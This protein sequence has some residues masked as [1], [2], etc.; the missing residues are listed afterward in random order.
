[1]AQVAD[2]LVDGAAN[3]KKSSDATTTALYTLL[4]LLICCTGLAMAATP[5]AATLHRF[6]DKAA[7]SLALGADVAATA[8]EAVAARGQFVVAVSGGSL[9]KLL[10]SGLIAHATGADGVAW[11]KWRVFFAD[12]RCVPHDHADSNQR[13]CEEAFL[14]PISEA[15][16]VTDDAARRPTVYGIDEALVDQPAAAAAAYQKALEGVAGGGGEGEACTVPRFDL[17]LLG[18][19]PD[20]HTCSLFP[21][22]ALFRGAA[23]QAAAGQWVAAIEDSPKPPAQRITLTLPVLNGARRVAFVA[24]GASKADVLPAAVARRAHGEGDGAAVLPAGSVVPAADGGAVAWYVDEAAAAQIP[25]NS[26]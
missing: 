18:M 24:A 15:L 26:L 13:G 20:G 5:P 22:H 6:A 10:A 19:G 9:P 16:G 23:E 14:Q 1:M 4:Q 2:A 7:L 3:P 12:E 17:V 25:P 11:G 21:G 8:R